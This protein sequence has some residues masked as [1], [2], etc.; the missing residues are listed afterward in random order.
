[1]FEFVI[2][3]IG[4]GDLVPQLEQGR[5]DLG[6]VIDDE[7]KDPRLHVEVLCSEP[8]SFLAE[9]GHPLA[10]RESVGVSDLCDQPFLLTDTGCAYRS[11]LEQVLGAGRN[12][13][14]SVMEFTSVETIKECVALGMGIACLPRI[15]ANSDITTRKLVAL[16]WCGP[17][18]TMRTLAAWH[19]GKWISP[20]LDAF[21][22]LLRKKLVNPKENL[23]TTRRRAI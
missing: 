17:D 21:L 18:L 15:V 3:G 20:A 1:V 4:N 13:F 16:P 7:I 22:A 19:K 8:M 10:D 9:Y 14:K 12:S 5:L 11:R 6:L 23:G 2:R